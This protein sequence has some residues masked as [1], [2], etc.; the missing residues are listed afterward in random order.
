MVGG[1]WLDHCVLPGNHKNGDAN[2][3]MSIGIKDSKLVVNCRAGCPQNELFKAIAARITGVKPKGCGITLARYAEMKKLPE[4][5]LRSVAGSADGEVNDKKDDLWL[6]VPTVRHAY[7]DE[8]LAVIGY[9]HRK[10]ESSHDTAWRDANDKVCGGAKFHVYGLHMLDPLDALDRV[11][12]VEGESDCQTLAYLGLPALGISGKKNWKP[13]YANLKVLVDARE[14]I[15]VQEPKAEDLTARIAADFPAK[16][17]VMILSAK[18]TSDLWLECGAD[19]DKFMAAWD[20][21]AL[22]ARS[23]DKAWR[24]K[25]HTVDELPDGDIDFLIDNFLPYGV[26]F[27]GALSGA[28][29]TWF[30]LSLA[31]AITTGQKLMANWSVPATADVLYLCP[32]M[33]AKAFKKRCR[34]FGIKEHFYCQT[35]ADGAP[36]DLADPLLVQ[37]VKE[38]KPV[39]FLDTAIRFS[40]AEDENSSSQN[41]QGIAKAVFGLIALG[42]R[43]VICLHHRAKETAKNNNREM[44]LENVLRGTGDLGAICDVVWGLQYDDGNGAG[45][46]YMKDS[47]RMV[48]LQAR[49]VKARDFIPPEDFRLQLDPFIDQVGDMRVLADDAPGPDGVDL[50]DADRVDAYVQEHR[51]DSPRQIERTGALKM[52]RTRIEKLAAKKGWDWNDATKQWQRI[53]EKDAGLGFI[54]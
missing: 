54:Q 32:E 43:A 45:P 1:E 20:K 40:H 50:A 41:A 17:K 35:I 3:S 34:K 42:A 44:T 28:G 38:L 13:E 5:W 36:L 52:R 31:R 12:L 21:A 53:P 15:V 4:E 39:I 46:Q 48:R 16:T 30:C 7:H 18:D 22:A 24:Q 9:K 33:S 6:K 23:L 47:R 10:S 25:F 11:Y 2:P 37:A 49:C 26:A 29:K 8:N 19:K 27:V 51:G 14:I